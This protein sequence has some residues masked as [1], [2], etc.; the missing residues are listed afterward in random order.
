[1]KLERRALVAGMAGTVVL[2]LARVP[3]AAA[4]VPDD[5]AAAIDTILAGREPAEDGLDLEVPRVAENGAQVP[6]TVR[7]DSPMTEDNHVTAIHIVATANPT[8]G[9]GTFRLTPHIARAEVFTRVRLAE[10]QD[11]LIL[12]E[13]S[14]GRVLR[15]V[16]RVT[17]SVGGCAT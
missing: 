10:E 12:A 15:A 8:P 1:M 3:F 9:I 7:V 5:V 16:A 4:A 11:L 14:D 2:S 6:I 13:L 17:V